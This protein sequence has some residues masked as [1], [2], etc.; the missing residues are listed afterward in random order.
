VRTQNARSSIWRESVGVV[1][2]L[3]RLPDSAWRAWRC[4]SCWQDGHNTR[5]WGWVSQAIYL[6]RR[7]YFAGA[8]FSRPGNLLAYHNLRI[9]WP[10]SSRVGFGPLE[11]LW[12]SLTYWKKQPFRIRDRALPNESRLLWHLESNPPPKV[13][14]ILSSPYKP[15]LLGRPRGSWSMFLS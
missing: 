13:G 6:Q 9:L 8:A 5:E 10:N 4:R 2:T 11:W 1:R 15:A 3:E 12:H 7:N 14:A